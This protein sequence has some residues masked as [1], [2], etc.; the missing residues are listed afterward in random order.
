MADESTL[1]LNPFDR[2]YRA[3]KDFPHTQP[4]SIPLSDALA[5][6]GVE[7]VTVQTFRIPEKGDVVLLTFVGADGGRREVLAPKVTKAVADQ[8]DQ[9]TKMSRRAQARQAAADR[10]ARGEKPGFQLTESERQER[11]ER[12]ALNQKAKGKK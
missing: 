11:A 9:L 2:A 12:R 7:N 10:K 4:R 5:I 3:V 6:G 1:S 8:R